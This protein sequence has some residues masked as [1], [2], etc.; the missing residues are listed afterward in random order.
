MKEL[1]GEYN[2]SG[3]MLRNALIKWYYGNEECWNRDDYDMNLPNESILQA[4]KD[5]ESLEGFIEKADNSELC[6]WKAQNGR[7]RP[8]LNGEHVSPMIP[9]S[10]F[11]ISS[12]T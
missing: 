1:E 2:K 6:G 7:G 8:S 10:H 4:V 3:G 12:L 11:S 5:N 9:I